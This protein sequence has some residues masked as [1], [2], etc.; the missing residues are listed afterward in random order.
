MKHKGICKYCRKL[1]HLC[2]GGHYCS[3]C[4]RKYVRKKDV[5]KRCKRL[6]II[7]G[8][9]YCGACYNYLGGYYNNTRGVSQRAKL[10]MRPRK[11]FFC[12][13]IRIKMLDIH[14]KIRGSKNPK[15][16]IFLCPNHHREV[17]LGWKKVPVDKST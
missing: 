5:C 4:Y 17:H 11:C 14:H 3:T 6:R 12:K 9:G 16:W 15:D 10:A 2:G 1:K 13:E 7:I 8:N